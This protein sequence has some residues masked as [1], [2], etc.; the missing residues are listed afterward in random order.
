MSTPTLNPEELTEIA[1][2]IEDVMQ[3]LQIIEQ[4]KDLRPMQYTARLSWEMLYK[5]REILRAKQSTL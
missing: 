5:Y 2:A 4:G 3:Q 1:Q